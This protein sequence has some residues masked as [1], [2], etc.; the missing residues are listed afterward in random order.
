MSRRSGTE[1]YLNSVYCD[2]NYGLGR[3]DVPDLLRAEKSLEAALTTSQGTTVL[4]KVS[5]VLFPHS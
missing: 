3:A 5:K 4:A 2:N 1:K